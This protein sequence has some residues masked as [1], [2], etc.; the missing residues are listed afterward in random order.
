[1]KNMVLQYY[2]KNY[3]DSPD[4]KCACLMS[5]VSTPS[6]KHN[7]FY[8]IILVFCGEYE[9]EMRG[10]NRIYQ[11]NSLLFFAPGT[12]HSIK[13][14]E[15]NSSHFAFLVSSDFMPIAFKA[16]FG[17]TK[18][19]PPRN[20]YCSSL[21]YSQ[22]NYM[23]FLAN[24]LTN[25]RLKEKHALHSLFLHNAL[26]AL[27]SSTAAPSTISENDYIDTLI[28]RLNN[29]DYVNTEVSSIYMDFPIAQS[30]LC[31]AFKRR[32]GMT[33]VNYRNMKKMEYAAQLLSDW[34]SNISAVANKINISC[35]SY[36][37]KQF[38]AHFGISPKDY[39]KSHRKP[40]PKDERV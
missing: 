27:F 24:S 25:M 5:T 20:F 1:M 3:T 11:K 40:F 39:Q 26:Y 28:E 10:K 22:C 12:T 21:T 15:P 4:D 23:N 38:R 30:T 36:F 37:S 2:F 31:A 33:I 17:D 19:I 9:I 35:L 14:T 8:E 7:D 6:H 29:F 34:N 13:M 32:T 18:D 16:F